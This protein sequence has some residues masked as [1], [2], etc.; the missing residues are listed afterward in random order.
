MSGQVLE[1]D[2]EI[3]FPHFTILKAS[4][5]S[6]K[7]HALTQRL[8]QFLLSDQ[9]ERNGLRNILAITFS[10]NAAKEMKD[11]TLLWLKSVCLDDRKAVDELHKIVFL[12]AVRMIEK[13]ESL[14]QN[15]FANY[16]DLQIRTIDSFM[17][18]VFKSSAMDFG[19]DPEFEILMNNDLLIEYSFDIFMRDVR[20]GSEK[21]KI[22]Q[23]I[24]AIIMEHKRGDSSYLW[25]PSSEIREEIKKIYRKLAST[26]KKARIE[27]L[28]EY[29]NALKTLIRNILNEIEA[30]IQRTG[31]QRNERSAYKTTLSY[32]MEGRYADIIG[33]GTKIPPVTKPKKG[34]EHLQQHY[35][36][37]IKMWS[38]FGDR[39]VQYTSLYVRTCYSPYLKVYEEFIETIESVKRHQGKIFIEDINWKLAD[40]LNS[41][42]VPD[43]YFRLGETIFHFLIDEF[44]DTSPIQWRNLQPLIENSLAE[45]GSFFAVG[46]TKQAIYGF[47]NADYSIMKTM[48]HVN[49]FP[50]ALHTVRELKTNH[51]SLQKILNFND[52]VFKEIVAA[53]EDYRDAAKESGLTDYIQAVKEGQKCQGHSEVIIIDKDEDVLPERKKIQELVLKLRSRG[54]R[55]RDI[56]IL[57]Q[58]N[59]D[60]VKVTTWLNE[61]DIPF[62]SYSSLDIR[63]QKVTA[64]IVALLNFLDSP[65]DNLSFATFILGDIFASNSLGISTDCLRDFIFSNRQ[66]R[67]LY[68]SFQK[69]FASLWDI[70]FSGLFKHSGYL[71]L[72][73]LVV[74]IFR[75]FRV[76]ESL[77]DEEA[78]LVKIL[79]VVKDIEGAGYNSIKNFLMLAASGDEN[80]ESNWNMAVP[81]NKDAVKVMTIHKSKGLGFPVV[82][83]M[84]YEERNRGFDYIV[85]EEG[86][87]MR[88]LKITKD[89]AQSDPLYNDLYINES[90]KGMV[91]KLNTLYV[92]FTRPKEELYVIGVKGNSDSYPLDILPV[93]D[94]PPAERPERKIEDETDFGNVFMIH[95]HQGKIEI[96]DGSDEMIN[97]EERRR[98]EFFHRILFFIEYIDEEFENQLPDIIQRVRTEMSA[99]Y[100]DSIVKEKIISFIRHKDITGYFKRKSGRRVLRE[101][102][103]ADEKGN[104]YRMDRIIVDR[105]RVTVIDYKTGSDREA[106]E[107]YNMKI[108]T[109]MNVL[110]EVFPGSTVYGLIAYIDLNEIRSLN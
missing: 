5:G 75:R 93:E 40:Y 59:E 55:F 20:E 51:R 88:L 79:E 42:I 95:H 23:D 73:D 36:N 9:I 65:T 102:E 49:P 54:Y 77:Q 100:P 45:N 99:E 76:F 7:T 101:Q 12:D 67:L 74:E 110:G 25:D 52:T 48:E 107:K 35:D 56:A 18:T 61:I 58:K 62:I 17:T 72:Y 57:T 105:D 68:K 98:G 83:V 87:E 86:D 108:K 43:I 104:L 97:L 89:T 13:A 8:V 6:G 33:R 85:M 3:S 15:I 38:Q 11:R 10:N 94:Y 39:M 4:A 69:E 82:I 44:Q 80:I 47:R 2:S 91:N 66:Q 103:F 21:A 32:V 46:D 64:E 90:M 71:P 30:E 1:K 92:G 27:D 34:Q 19:Y 28:S 106:E 24:I 41:Q 53:H 109:Y 16:A 70:Y 31:L 26:G 63:R 81:K 14:I 37:V 60:A 22:L 78:V 96:P 84:L 29:M 50:S